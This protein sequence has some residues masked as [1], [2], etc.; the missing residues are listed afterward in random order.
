MF[1][2]GVDRPTSW[3]TT[4][5]WILR[6]SPRSSKT[7]VQ[8]GHWIKQ[9]DEALLTILLHLLRGVP[10]GVFGARRPLSMQLGPQVSKTIRESSRS[11]GR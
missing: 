2:A 8:F 7:P 10:Q 11:N 3:E 6:C 4:S 1:S 9:W 5:P